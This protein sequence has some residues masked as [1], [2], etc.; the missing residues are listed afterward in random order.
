[1]ILPL[2]AAHYLPNHAAVA[3]PPAV[4][5]APAAPVV[6]AAP[7]APAVVAAP[8]APVVVA[9]PAAPAV[10]VPAAPV[11]V[12]A[13]AAPAVAAAPAAPV[14]GRRAGGSEVQG[15]RG[16]QGGGRERGRQGQGRGRRQ[17]GRGGHKELLVLMPGCSIWLVKCQDLF[18][19]VLDP[20][21][22]ELALLLQVGEEDSA[23]IGLQDRTTLYQ[24]LQPCII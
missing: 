5:A 7:A 2:V 20:L 11:V 8:A 3:P 4:A 9:A 13:P 18:V 22:F 21:G 24:H 17:G 10:A 19:D 1:M 23:A 16:G 15:W 14:G 12:A 6:V